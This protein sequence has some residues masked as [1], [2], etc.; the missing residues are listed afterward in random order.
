MCEDFVKAN[1]RAIPDFPVKGINFWD[2][3]HLF[4]NPQALSQ[5]S[6]SL[7][8]QYKDK[9]ITKVV[10][11]ESRGFVMGAILAARLGAGFVMIRKKGKLP[12]D[13]V[14]ESYT[15]EYGEDIIE[16]HTDA[17]SEGETV[18]IH[19][20]LLATGGTLGAAYR[21]VSRFS[22]SKIYVNCM[23][24]IVDCPRLE[25]FTASIKSYDSL[26]KV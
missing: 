9:G 19:D 23:I 2:V 8:G 5:L 18:L 16:I 12:G 7:Y 11:L 22:P 4:N 1:L 17:I 6:D 3:D 21:L 10:A 25:S 13:C 15:K 26:I 20:D 24:D 14:S